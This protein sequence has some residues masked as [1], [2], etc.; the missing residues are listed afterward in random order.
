M[1]TTTLTFRKE[2]DNFK[3]RL[4]DRFGVLIRQRETFKFITDNDFEED[5]LENFCD[6]FEL[7]NDITG[8]VFD[9]FIVS[10]SEGEILAVESE[11][12]EKFHNICFSDLSSVEDRINLI[13]VMENYLNKDLVLSE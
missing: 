3:K 12:R 9:V 5:E 2:L 13:E 8:G 10:I 7:R 6:Y 1:E 4:S 11:N